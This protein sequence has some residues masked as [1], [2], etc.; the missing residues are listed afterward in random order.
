MMVSFFTLLTWF[1]MFVGLTMQL[2]MLFLLIYA[3][4][5]FPT[6]DSTAGLSLW[7]ITQLA[8]L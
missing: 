4:C 1:I 6:I 8:S 2:P 7:V 3:F 5:C